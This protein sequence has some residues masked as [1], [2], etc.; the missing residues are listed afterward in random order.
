MLVDIQHHQSIGPH[1]Q[2]QH[3]GSAYVA[4]RVFGADLELESAKTLVEST[5]GKLRYL[6]VLVTEPADRGV[7]S[8][9]SALQNGLACV[10]RG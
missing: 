6:L 7:V 3:V 2:A 9:I 1:Q 10:A 5:P 4:V 8:R